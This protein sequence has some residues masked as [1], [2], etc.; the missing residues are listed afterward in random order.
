MNKIFYFLVIFAFISISY[1]IPAEYGIGDFKEFV[2]F[3]YKIEYSFDE[4]PMNA[5]KAALKFEIECT[6]NRTYP[7]NSIGW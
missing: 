4:T 1:G 3:H 2:S 6:Q 7:F 5:T